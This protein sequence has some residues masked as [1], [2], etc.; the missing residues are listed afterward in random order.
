MT[1]ATEHAGPTRVLIAANHLPTRTG[2]RLALE[3]D[4]VCS[5]AADDEGAVAAAVREHPDVCLLEL[6]GPGRGLGT[7]AEIIAQVPGALVIVLS[8]RVAEDEFLAALRA[9]ASGYLPHNVN[10]ARLPLVVRSV[11]RGEAAVPRTFVAKLIEELRGSSR[12]RRALV[13]Q[14]GTRLELTPRE[15]EVLELAQQGLSTREIAVRLGIS[16]VTVR[17]HLAAAYARLGVST[18]AAALALL[19][20]APAD[21]SS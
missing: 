15:S 19:V 10:P 1:A 12:G 11:L 20:P 16:P 8:D 5:E 4:A 17:R 3:S 13:L 21:R 6:G 18:R 9:G 14:D 2:L 7:V